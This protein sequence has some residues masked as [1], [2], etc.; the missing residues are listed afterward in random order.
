MKALEESLKP[1]MGG[2]DVFRHMK[3]NGWL[4]IAVQLKAW[5]PKT[6][7][8]HQKLS[9]FS[10]VLIDD[11]RQ[12]SQSL[13][14]KTSIIHLGLVDRGLRVRPFIIQT[15]ELHIYNDRSAFYATQ[16]ERESLV[17]MWENIFF[18]W[19]LAMRRSGLAWRD[20]DQELSQIADQKNRIPRPRDMRAITRNGATKPVT[21]RGRYKCIATFDQLVIHTNPYRWWIARPHN[22]QVVLQ[23]QAQDEKPLF[24]F[25]SE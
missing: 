9:E 7:L 19:W 6:A 18:F 8:P 21:S 24:Q 1:I 20:I 5:T 11:P 25:S 22:L 12:T 16:D 14:H 17:E 13:G 4:D 15:P 23:I 3:A 2:R 10:I